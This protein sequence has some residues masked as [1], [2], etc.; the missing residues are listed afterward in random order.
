MTGM[1]YESMQSFSERRGI[2]MSEL[3]DRVSYSE[4]KGSVIFQVLDEQLRDAT[5]VHQLKDAMLGIVEK[6]HPQNIIVDLQRV[7][8][9]G[10]VGFLAFLALR[11]VTGI[12][13]IVLCEVDKNVLEIFHLCRL[14]ADKDSPKAPFQV[15]KTLDDAKSIVASV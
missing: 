7:T 13:K 1:L 3:E 14:V 6:T 15:A 4:D 9:I 12:E 10:S 8:F 2:G 11:R 5:K